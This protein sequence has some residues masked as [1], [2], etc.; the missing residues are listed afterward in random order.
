MMQGA[1]CEWHTGDLMG[2]SHNCKQPDAA[3][4]GSVA[5]HGS[6]TVTNTMTSP[7]MH[8]GKSKGERRGCGG[9]CSRPGTVVTAAASSS[10]MAVVASTHHG[11]QS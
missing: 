11:L 10:R 4:G 9:I 2:R 8:R 1:L 6:H 5:W 3:P 7:A